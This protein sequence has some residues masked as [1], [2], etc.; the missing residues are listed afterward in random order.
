M[1][2]QKTPEEIQAQI[3]QMEKRIRDLRKQKQTVTAAQR[4]KY[5]KD[6]LDALERWR[7]SFPNP[8]AWEQLAEWFD[9][10]AEKNR[11][12]YG[13]EKGV[14]GSPLPL[15]EPTTIGTMV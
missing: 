3:E 2:R 14:Q 12:K 1:S 6:I 10:T 15:G 13:A 8:I 7:T 9:K 5:N 11:K 4:A